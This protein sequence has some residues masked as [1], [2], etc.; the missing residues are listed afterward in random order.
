[1]KIKVGDFDVL[2]SGSVVG[3]LNEPIDFIIN[4]VTG[5]IVRLTFTEDT[6]QKENQRK[7]DHFGDSG[8]EINFINYTNSLGAGNVSPLRIGMFN[9]RELYLNYRIYHIDRLGKQ[10]HYTWLLG[11]EI[12]NG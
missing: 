10:I 3:T 8:V 9:K 6:N 5:F 1:M 2:D 12:T 7:A 11:K 4:E